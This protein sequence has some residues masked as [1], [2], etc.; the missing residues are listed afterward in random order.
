MVL[1]MRAALCNKANYT[2]FPCEK[3][4]KEEK[5]FTTCSHLFPL[6]FHSQSTTGSWLIHS[7]LT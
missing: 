6:N 5:I 7:L 2:G 1:R 4:K 3:A